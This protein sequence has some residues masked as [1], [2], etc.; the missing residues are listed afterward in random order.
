MSR[1][2]PEV[3]SDDSSEPRQGEICLAK[4][5]LQESPCTSLQVLMVS[6]RRRT[7]VSL[8]SRP[9]DAP[10]KPEFLLRQ[11]RLPPSSKPST[12]MCSALVRMNTR[13]NWAGPMAILRPSSQLQEN[14]HRRKRASSSTQAISRHSLRKSL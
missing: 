13:L 7:T 1:L 10:T 4:E 11:N 14:C 2:M 6:S 9:L 3:N 12:V 5:I 8:G